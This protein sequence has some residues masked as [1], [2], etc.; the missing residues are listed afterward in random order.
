MFNIFIIIYIYI[1]TASTPLRK[2]PG[3]FESFGRFIIMLMLLCVIIMFYAL[4]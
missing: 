2:D 1:I 3:M 4:F